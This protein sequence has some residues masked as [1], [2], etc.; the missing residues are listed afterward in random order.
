MAVS[1]TANKTAIASN[2]EEDR[3]LSIPSQTENE[4]EEKL[5]GKS[6]GNDIDKKVENEE[7]ATPTPLVVA[8]EYSCDVCRGPDVGRFDPV[9]YFIEY[10]MRYFDEGHRFC[11]FKCWHCLKLFS[12]S[13]NGDNYITLKKGRHPLQVRICC[14]QKFGCQSAICEQCMT[15]NMVQTKRKRVG[16]TYS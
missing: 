3:G 1:D 8:K 13:E 9:N 10:D 12:K 15:K 6:S 11:G 16:K 5:I 14:N 2:F 7:T 4:L